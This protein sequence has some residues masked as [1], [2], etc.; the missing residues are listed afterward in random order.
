MKADTEEL[1]KDREKAIAGQADMANVRAIQDF[2]Q[3]VGTGWGAEAKLEAARI[4]KGD[5]RA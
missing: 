1:A 3:K 4:L 2:L 5:R